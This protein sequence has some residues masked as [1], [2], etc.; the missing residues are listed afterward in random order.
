MVGSCE[1]ILIVVCF[2]NPFPTFAKLKDN[3]HQTKKL[4]TPPQKK[5][6]QLQPQNKKIFENLLAPP[7][8]VRLLRRTKVCA[9]LMAV[10]AASCGDSMG[11]SNS[12]SSHTFPGGVDPGD[13]RQ[14]GRFSW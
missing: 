5:N 3:F 6:L 7:K 10:A 13:L 4:P 12:T 9:Q 14:V 2:W 8:E 1:L 11:K